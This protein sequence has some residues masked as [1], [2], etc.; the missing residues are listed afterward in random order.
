M[1]TAE[2][3]ERLAHIAFAL[4]LL[5]SVALFSDY[6][7]APPPASAGP[8]VASTPPPHDAALALDAQAVSLATCDR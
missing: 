3:W 2:V 8:P 5:F 1:R 7:I 6:M 4:L